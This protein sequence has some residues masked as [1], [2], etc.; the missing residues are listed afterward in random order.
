MKKDRVNFSFSHVRI[1]AGTDVRQK[2][3]ELY[4]RRYGNMQKKICEHSA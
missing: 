2:V 3:T 4:N 1:D